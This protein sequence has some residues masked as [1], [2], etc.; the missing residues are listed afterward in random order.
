MAT[1]QIKQIKSSIG[2]TVR[3]KQTLKALGLRKINHVVEHENVP[4][5]VGM[6][7]KVKHLVTVNEINK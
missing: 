3:Q 1:L 4:Q 6:I 2:Q 7:N 5:I